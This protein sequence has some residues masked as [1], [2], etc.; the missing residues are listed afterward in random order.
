M[1]K[2]FWEE[3]TIYFLWYGTDC[4]EN[5]IS[6]NSLPSCYLA[7]IGNTQTHRHM[8]PTV[9]LLLLLFVV[10][11]TCL[12]SHCLAMKWRIYFTELLSGK[13][14]RDTYTD[15]L[16]GGIYEVRCWDGLRCHDVP[17]KFCTYWF[18]H[19]KV[20]GVDSQTHGQHDDHINLLPF[21]QNKKSKLKIHNISAARYII[22]C[23]ETY[24]NPQ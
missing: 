12:P 3:L 23:P 14:K 21:L 24:A 17:T 2:K 18:R 1:N 11:G 4:I 6:N 10:V 15:K 16:M 8:H 20:N 7:I 19:S 13:D 9:L 5:N 22:K